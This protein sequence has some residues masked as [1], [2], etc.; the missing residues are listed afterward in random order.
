MRYETFKFIFENHNHFGEF[1]IKGG[2]VEQFSEVPFKLPETSEI[3]L[4]EI[5]IY[6][7]SKSLK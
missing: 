7:L 4:R 3:K 6:D 1:I 2:V 5:K